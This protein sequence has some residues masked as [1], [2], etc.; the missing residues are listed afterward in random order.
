MIDGKCRSPK[1]RPEC[2]VAQDAEKERRGLANANRARPAELMRPNPFPVHRRFPTF[3]DDG[4]ENDLFS[5]ERDFISELIIVG[6][7]IHER[8]EAAALF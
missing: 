6:Q 3:N 7:K 4:G 1:Q 8:F 2:G 5:G